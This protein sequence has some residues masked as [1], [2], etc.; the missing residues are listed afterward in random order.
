[1]DS[2]KAYD[3]VNWKFLREVLMR[4]GFDTGFIHRIIQL[5]AG[6]QTSIATN[7]IVGPYFRNKRGVCQGDP[8]SLLLVEFVVDALSLIL[9]KAS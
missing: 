1:L 8:I 4:K 3:R 6:G 9:S 2:E 7:G 5:V